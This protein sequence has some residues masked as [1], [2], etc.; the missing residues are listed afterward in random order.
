MTIGE[1][2]KQ[3]LFGRVYKGVVENKGGIRHSAAFKEGR[4]QMLFISPEEARRQV[5]EDF[6]TART[7]SHPQLLHPWGLHDGGALGWMTVW[8]W[9]T[10]VSVR[11]VL[12]SQPRELDP[13]SL[14][15]QVAS[16]VRYCT[17]EGHC[18]FD[19]HFDDCFLQSSGN[20]VYMD[21][22]GPPCTELGNMELLPPSRRSP[23]TRLANP[24]EMPARLNAWVGWV[25]ALAFIL[26][27]GAPRCRGCADG[28]LFLA[29][30]GEPEQLM[31]RTDCEALKEKKR[32]L[33]M[34]QALNSDDA[35]G[36]ESLICWL[37]KGAGFD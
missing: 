19:A 32:R 20:L 17:Q 15:K 29:T 37:A 18:L 7:L 6:H 1:F 25:Y 16:V 34:T 4:S 28:C 23:D 14:I 12:E 10:G 8:P 27:S 13:G 11:Q 33:I 36:W 24:D 26:L 22:F 3:G 31:Q 30:R 35:A 5:L 9:V 21:V 2:V